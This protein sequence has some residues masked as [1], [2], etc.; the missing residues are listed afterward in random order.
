MQYKTKHKTKGRVLRCKTRPFAYMPEK[1]WN[2]A[3]KPL[4][5]HAC[6]TAI[7][8]FL[9]LLAVRLNICL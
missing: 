3:G 7:Y 2:I 9:F 5:G 1:G 4:H 8:F 6:P